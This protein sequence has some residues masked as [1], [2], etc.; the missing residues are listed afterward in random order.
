MNMF[1]RKQKVT[2]SQA[3]ELN[4][5]KCAAKV[6]D[7]KKDLT[8]RMRHLKLFVEMSEPHS[9]AELKHF[10]ELNY[11]QLYMLFYES[12]VSVEQNIKQ[13]LSKPNKEELETC[14]Y[15]LQKLLV[16]Q[17]ER[18]HQRWQVRSIGRIIQKLLH[19]GN[20]KSLKFYGIRLFLIWYQ[21]LNTNRTH[22][23]ELMFQRLIHGFDTAFN[24]ATNSFVALNSLAA[25]DMLN[26]EAQKIFGGGGGSSC[27]GGGGGDSLAAIGN[28][29][30]PPP[31]HLFFLP[32]SATSSSASVHA[33][34]TPSSSSFSVS[35]A[36]RSINPL[37]L[38]PIIPLQPNELDQQQ[39][40]QLLIQSQQ[41]QQQQQQFQHQ[42]MQQQQSSFNYANSFSSSSSYYSS[43]HSLT[44]EMLRKMLEYM[45]QDVREEAKKKLEFDKYS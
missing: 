8:S 45:Q 43:P 5:K 26:A 18:L 22:V 24:A 30:S 33:A 2:N 29:T 11:T 31:Q 25:L 17:P 39:Q 41:Q 1:G 3:D 13:K 20:T 44:A 21:I 37:E 19:V 28:G 12:F 35:L 9:V 23:E 7:V 6:L 15:V 4:R 40:Q 36:A 27:G 32:S 38:T 16:L 10:F 42:Q 14:L 34:T